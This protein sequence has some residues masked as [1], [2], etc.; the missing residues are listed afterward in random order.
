M[1]WPFKLQCRGNTVQRE[2][3]S[4]PEGTFPI[5]FFPRFMLLL[6]AVLFVMH[7]AVAIAFCTLE[8]LYDQFFTQHFQIC[9][10]IR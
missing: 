2:V 6:L 3:G 1:R 7:L 4:L 5:V 10:P 8:S 9:S